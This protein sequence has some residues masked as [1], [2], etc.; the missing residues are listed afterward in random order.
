MGCPCTALW[1]IQNL[2]PSPRQNW[3]VSCEL[4]WASPSPPH[5]A[6]RALLLLSDPLVRDPLVWTEQLR[7]EKSCVEWDKGSHPRADTLSPWL[8]VTSSLRSDPEGCC[9]EAFVSA[10]PW[11]GSP[12]SEL[13]PACPKG[14]ELV[15]TLGT[16]WFVPGLCPDITLPPGTP[17][18]GKRLA[19][20]G[21][22]QDTRG[23]PTQQRDRPR[24][25][26]SHP[27]ARASHACPRLALSSAG[28][29]KYTTPQPQSIP[30]RGDHH[31]ALEAAP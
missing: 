26:T 3:G 21:T 18:L 19:D 30:E 2:V 25:H 22:L 13:H 16:A 17:R 10:S 12:N 6:S 29:T 31:V 14:E 1:A 7:K 4:T 27:G 9:W 8:W 24:G 20:H 28:E 15:W 23:L 11:L 5:G